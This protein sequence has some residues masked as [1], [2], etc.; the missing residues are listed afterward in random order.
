VSP[1]WEALVADD[2]E[3]VMPLPIKRKLGIPFLVQPILTQQLGVFSS[4]KIDE[5]IVK[6][7][8]EKIPYRSY[9]LCLNEKNPN[10]NRVE[11]PNFVLNLNRNYEDIFAGYSTNTKR[12]INKTH[13]YPIEI[14]SDLSAND[15]LEF[16]HT[17]EKKYNELPQTKL[18][19]LV[20]ESFSKG[21]ATIY[22]AYN[23][24]HKLISALFLLHSNQRLIYLL[25]VSDQ[26]G[27]EFLAM[28]K[29][30]D[31]IIQHHAHS[32]CLLDFAGS[33]VANIARF[34]EGFGTSINY[35][36]E[37]KHW[38]INDFINRFCFRK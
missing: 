8:I 18:D 12:N 30:V 23:G 4:S 15:F 5:I 29:I 19:K 37:V 26:E 32:N 3:Y 7:F 2:Y 6:Q 10:S 13:Q 35:Y 21:K 17:I 25:P 1:N 34:Y 36:K 9:H 22:G 27:K 16:Y 31:E 14:K 38:S 28:F 24:E 20:V 33:N 11:H